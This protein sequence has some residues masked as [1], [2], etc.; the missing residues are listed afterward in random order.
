MNYVTK[1]ITVSVCPEG[2]DPLISEKS[3]H[4]SVVD[5]GGGAFI[6]IHEMAEGKSMKFNPDE[7]EPVFT[8]AKKLIESY[9]ENKDGKN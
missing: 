7:L 4:I 8:A 2:E 3:F 1:Y 5:D 9:E 6:E